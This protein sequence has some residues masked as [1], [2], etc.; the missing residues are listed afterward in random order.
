MPSKKNEYLEYNGLK[1]DPV[2]FKQGFVAGC[3]M[4]ICH[5]ECCYKG[6]YLDKEFKKVILDHKDIIKEA[7]DDD[8]IK[9]ESKWFDEEEIEDTDFPS[10]IASG[11]SVYKDKNGI[12]RC[13]FNDE[14]YFCSLQ[15]AAVKSGMHKWAIKP[16]FCILYPI[17]IADGIITYDD[18]HS[19][20]LSYCGIDLEENFTRTV[21]DATH[22]E[23]KYV[24]G[25]E[26]F[27]FLYKHYKNNYPPKFKR[28]V[29]N[30]TK[31]QIKIPEALN[32]KAHINNK[33]RKSIKP[34]FPANPVTDLNS[35]APKDGS[36][37]KIQK[38]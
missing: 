8:Q 25:E 30:P 4:K 3:D 34:V 18:S 21:F 13:V 22:E 12:E 23:I 37:K 7:M 11:T 31:Y 5:G 2:I 14:N 33:K 1:T 38:D 29:K 27:T 35:E 26:F 36:L 20:D 17:T 9:D 24:F 32:R 10:G 28:R 6:V 19:K 16:A 15:V